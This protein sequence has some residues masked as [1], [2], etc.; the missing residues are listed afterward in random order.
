MNTTN[1]ENVIV[2]PGQ[3]KKVSILSDK[4][5]KEQAFLYLFPKIKTGYNAPKGIPISPDR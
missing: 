5:F 1:D 3:A 2:A 4:F